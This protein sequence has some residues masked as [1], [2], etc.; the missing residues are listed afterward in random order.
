MKW[1]KEKQL[2]IETNDD[3]D[4]DKSM[5][6]ERQAGFLFIPHISQV[7]RCYKYKGRAVAYGL[8]S[9]AMSFL[10]SAVNHVNWPLSEPLFI[11]HQ[12]DYKHNRMPAIFGCGKR[13]HI[14]Q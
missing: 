13:F 8:R 11:C 9:N 12:T 3:V 6:G 7:I 10:Y 2:Y 14:G 1:A 5:N 4:A